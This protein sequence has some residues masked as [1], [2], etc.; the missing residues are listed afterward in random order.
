[1]EI[2]SRPCIS[3]TVRARDLK[4]SDNIVHTSRVTS[5]LSCV[6]CHM[7]HVKLFIKLYD[8]NNLDLLARPSTW[9]LKICH[10]STACSANNRVVWPYH[11]EGCGPDSKQKDPWSARRANCSHQ[12]QARLHTVGFGLAEGKGPTASLCADLAKGQVACAVPKLRRIG[13]K[14]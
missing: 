9:S 4:I 1:M 3:Q 2:S 6:T 10:I 5:H 14:S 12:R 13:S 7:S 11:Q 8:K